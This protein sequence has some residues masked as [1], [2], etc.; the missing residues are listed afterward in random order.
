MIKAV[1]FDLDGT[2][3][4]SLSDLANATN[5][6]ISKFGFPER[7]TEE[8]KYFAGDGMPKMIERALPE[9][10]KNT[11]NVNKVMPIFLRYYGEHYCDNTK[12]YAGMPELIDEL[13]GKSIMVAV[14]TNKN[15]AMAEKVVNKLYGDRF[16]LILG[17][18]E[19]IPAKPDPTAALIA[20]ETLGVKPDEC[21][22]VGDSMMDVM[23][24]VNSGAYPVGVL[25]GFRKKDE[26]I[27]GG[28]KSIIDNPKELLEIIENL[29]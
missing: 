4:N 13:K 2:L 12:A 28:A 26:L 29:G 16:D 25:W 19:G 14:V 5:Y 11:D 18:R 3:A 22:F 9:N 6:A 10:D 7:E 8:F 1:L 17:K 20:M 24:G 21:V 27:S 15:Q 23:T